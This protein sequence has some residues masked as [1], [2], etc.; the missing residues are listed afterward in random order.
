[1]WSMDLHFFF[2]NINFG[3]AGS[4]SDSLNVRRFCVPDGLMAFLLFFSLAVKRIAI[5][6]SRSVFQVCISS[7]GYFR[8]L[9]IYFQHF[10][11]NL[12]N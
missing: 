12:F 5:L 3:M 2:N 6:I 9:S 7:I 10:L 8:S 11:R 1:M 4:V